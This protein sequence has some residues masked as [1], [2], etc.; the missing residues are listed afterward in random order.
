MPG[1]SQL[2]STEDDQDSPGLFPRLLSRLRQ[3]CP[4]RGQRGRGDGQQGPDRGPPHRHDQGL[5]HQPDQRHPGDHHHHHALHWTDW[6]RPPLSAREI[7]I[8]NQKNSNVL[9]LRKSCFH[10]YNNISS[11]F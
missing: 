4:C 8:R 3:P 1:F 10:V 9:T 6:R 2:S 11:K 7:K 5:G